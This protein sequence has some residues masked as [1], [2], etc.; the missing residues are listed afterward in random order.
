MVPIRCHSGVAQELTSNQE[1]ATV[2]AMSSLTLKNVPPKI[3]ER[4]KKS[5]TVNFR[6]ITQEAFAR[7][8]MSFE[9]EEAETTR[10]HQRLIDEALAS[11]PAQPASKNQWE[12]TRARAL[13]RARRA[14]T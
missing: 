4:L 5:A 6:S 11:G 12:K 1:F 3:H 9:L 8:Q 2:F 13:Q 10:L 14:K 7:L